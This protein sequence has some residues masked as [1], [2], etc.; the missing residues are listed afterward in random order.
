MAIKL[1]KLKD[2]VI[3]IKDAYGMANQLESFKD[4]ILKD[5]R[6]ISGTI[7]GFLPVSGTNRNRIG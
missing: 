1:K 4:E 3:V 6:I 5:N 7:S 2:Q